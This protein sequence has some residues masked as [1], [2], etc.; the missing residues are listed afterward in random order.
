MSDFLRSFIPADCTLADFD[1][2]RCPD[3]GCLHYSGSIEDDDG[4]VIGYVT[5]VDGGDPQVHWE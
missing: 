4:E 1:V 5:Y 2:A 3:T